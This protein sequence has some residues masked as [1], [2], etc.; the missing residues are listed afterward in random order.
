MAKLSFSKRIQHFA[1]TRE[2]LKEEKHIED[3]N[4]ELQKYGINLYSVTNN[5]TGIK[6]YRIANL[7][8]ATSEIE[9]CE[10]STSSFMIREIEGDGLYFFGNK[11][12]FYKSLEA[13]RIEE[14][15][16]AD[17][18]NNIIKIYLNKKTAI[19][20]GE[21]KDFII[22]F[23]KGK[24]IQKVENIQIEYIETDKV[25]KASAFIMTLVPP[26]RNKKRL[27]IFE[28]EGR[29]GFYNIGEDIIKEGLWIESL[30]E[31]KE[32]IKENLVKAYDPE[33]GYYTLISYDKNNGTIKRWYD[34]EILNQL[35]ET[36]YLASDKD[37]KFLTIIMKKENETTNEVQFVPIGKGP[38]GKYKYLIEIY[39]MYIFKMEEKGAIIVL[40]IRGDRV[41]WKR[42]KNAKDIDI[43]LC[44]TFESDKLIYIQPKMQDN[45]ETLDN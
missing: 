11:G 18:T 7:V 32:L 43:V 24:V 4:S 19:I 36:Y 30:E 26:I 41:N 2:W 38:N 31:L 6:S 40:L 22:K 3:E 8:D 33:K 25:Y 28:D 37:S 29:F 44:D 45:K 16:V 39:G 5:E 27:V 21:K 15:F 34:F 14:S 9:I 20:L 13:G 35:N 42:Y 23:K 17:F 12:I 1:A 10:V